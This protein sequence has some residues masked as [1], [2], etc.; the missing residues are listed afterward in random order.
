MSEHATAETTPTFRPR[1]EELC[2]LP[3]VVAGMNPLVLMSLTYM[4]RGTSNDPE[5]IRVYR[6]GDM[7][8]VHDGRHRSMAAQIA[9]R[10]DVLATVIPNPREQDNRS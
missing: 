10:P 8:R 4:L 5:P 2:Y 7:W 9:G 3:N 6:D 1:V